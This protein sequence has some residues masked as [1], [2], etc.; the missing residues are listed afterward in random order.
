[1]TSSKSLNS[2]KLKTI[3]CTCGCT[4]KPEAVFLGA[5]VICPVCRQPWLLAR[6]EK[7]IIVHEV[8]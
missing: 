7:A 5:K 8:K 2:K 1:M 6:V 3:Q 4:I